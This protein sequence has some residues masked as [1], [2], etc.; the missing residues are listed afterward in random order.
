MGTPSF[1]YFMKGIVKWKISLFLFFF[2]LWE[3]TVYIL[4]LLDD[5]SQIK[6]GTNMSSINGTCVRH[7][8][9]HPFTP[10]TTLVTHRPEDVTSQTTPQPSGACFLVCGWGQQVPRE[11]VEVTWEK[12]CGQ[13]KERRRKCVF[14]PWEVGLGRL[15]GCSGKL[16]KERRAELAK[17]QHCV[18][19]S[20]CC[21][22][23]G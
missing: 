13:S 1:V 19:V 2:L 20:R 22:M 7:R 9:T 23:S 14:L 17:A 15:W 21:S 11:V 12:Q 3:I 18:V 10:S 16:R 8:L 5:Y 6:L 4:N